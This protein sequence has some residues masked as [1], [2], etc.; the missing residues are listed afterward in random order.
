EGTTHTYTF[1]VSDP[2]QD[3]FS[4]DGGYPA[5]GTGGQ[6]VT[7]THSSDATGG[8]FDCSFPDGPAQTDVKIKVTDSDGAS[9]I[10]SESVQVV[11][12]ANVAPSVT[13]PADQSTS[14]GSSHSFA[15]G[16]FSDPGDDSPWHVSVNWGDG[17]FDSTFDVNTTVTIPAQ[18]HTYADGPSEHTVTVTVDDGTDHTS[19]TFSVHVDNVS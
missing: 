5:C 16:S 9:D 13:A 3:S 19:K 10:G 2:G 1:T 15:L 4:V 8:S 17:S 6:Y 14:E 18:A 11:Q 7:G 12:V